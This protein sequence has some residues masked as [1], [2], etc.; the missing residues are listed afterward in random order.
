MKKL[1]HFFLK[2][3]ILYW[4]YQGL[5]GG[6]KARRWFI[7]KD[8]RPLPGQKVL[9]IGCGP[10]NIIDYLPDVNYLGLDSD[11]SYINAAKRN[12]G[13]KG[14][15]IC[16]DIST[17]KV[18]DPGTYDIVMASGILHH[19]DDNTVRTFYKIAKEA[20]KPSGRLITVDGC[21]IDRQ[22][23]IAKFLL[24][25]D[26]GQYIRIPSHYT[27]LAKTSFTNVAADIK[28]NY[29]NVPYTLIVIECIA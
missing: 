7:E 20:L 22:N 29:F 17:F 23:S 28:H 1:A 9:D 13:D 14:H 2:N 16:T 21:F 6:H 10:G 26:R 24:K 11:E 27:T 4:T 8:V 15:F 5:V 25:S 19:L 18:P 12:Y 3:P